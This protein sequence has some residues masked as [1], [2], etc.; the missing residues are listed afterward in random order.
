MSQS[1]RLVEMDGRSFIVLPIGVI[2]LDEVPQAFEGDMFDCFTHLIPDV[3]KLFKEYQKEIAPCDMLPIAR[4]CLA[5]EAMAWVAST[6]GGSFW[7]Y[8]G[9]KMPVS[10]RVLRL[11]LTD[12]VEVP[13]AA[14][15][16]RA[17]ARRQATEIYSAMSPDKKG[18]SDTCKRLVSD[19]LNDSIE[20]YIGRDQ[21]ESC[22]A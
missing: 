1:V 11:C 9:E 17:E 4:Y 16:D 7:C 18:L 3:L 2:G 5:M 20:R 14:A 19:W 10:L 8:K 15:P 12:Q 21:E 22:L 6:Q 13:L